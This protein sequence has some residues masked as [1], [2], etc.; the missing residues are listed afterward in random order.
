LSNVVYYKVKDGDTVFRIAT[1]F[2]ISIE[3]LYKDNHLK[4]DSVIAPGE[5]IKV[6]KTGAR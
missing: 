6:T 5:I 1:A 3:Q 2:G 4:P